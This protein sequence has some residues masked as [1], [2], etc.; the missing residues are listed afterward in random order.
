MGKNRQKSVRIT[1]DDL[2]REFENMENIRQKKISGGSFKDLK[3]VDI[4]P[5]TPNQSRV[6]EEYEGENNLVLY[7]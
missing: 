3:M 2:L 1:D 6:F 4:E 7:G 5:L